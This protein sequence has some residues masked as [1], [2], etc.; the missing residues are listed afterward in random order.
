M[1]TTKSKRQ[2]LTVPPKFLWLLLALSAC[3]ALSV[4]AALLSG[5]APNGNDRLFLEAPGWSRAQH[6]ANTQT[7]DAASIVLDDAGLIY[8]AVIGSEGETSRPKVVAL[9]R[10]GEVTWERSLDIALT[11][12]DKPRLLWDGQQL[13]LYWIDGNSLFGAAIDTSGNVTEAP[14]L[15]S[16]EVNVDSYAIAGTSEGDASVWFAGPR[17]EPGLY[18]LADSGP[19]Q[20][21]VLVDAAGI[22]PSVQY[23]HEGALHATWAQHPAGSSTAQFFYGA[24]PNGDYIPG[25]QSI[26]VEPLLAPTSALRG[27]FLGLDRQNSHIFWSIEIRTG[28]EA[29]GSKTSY[30][31]FPLGEPS[32]VSEPVRVFVPTERD[33]AYESIT[34]ES[35]PAGPRIPLQP[36]DFAGTSAMRGISANPASEPELALALSSS[37]EHLWSKSAVQVGALFIRDGLA[38]DYQL[39]SFTT[40][41][42][43]VPSLVSDAA[44]NLY[45]S[46]IEPDDEGG[47]RAYFASTAPD[48][49]GALRSLTA[50]DIGRF[51]GATTFGLVTGALLAPIAAVLWLLIPLA[52]LALTSP[53]RRGDQQL[54]SPGTAVSLFLAVAA[55]LAVKFLSIPGIRDYVPFSAWLPLPEWLQAPLQYVVPVAITIVALLTA[56]HF[57]YRRGRTSPLFFIMIFAAMDSVLTLAV[58]GVVVL[59]AF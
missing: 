55:Y 9:D 3:A 37:V 13:R 32:A 5:C 34:D 28:M 35:L 25:R 50:L 40:T 12:P 41:V 8:M 26:V 47:F 16:G 31:Y 38:S 45:I 21:P 59:G 36:G 11:H 1:Q 52:I 46:W 43:S 7:N 44:G 18:H 33:L 54:S 17:R 53:L 10:R 2:L 29:G 6:V 19:D 4:C 30:V 42:S 22:R 48:I 15:L 56:W 14:A 27:P 51:A 57:T 58:Y 24:Y 49:Q 20:G 23:D 39:L